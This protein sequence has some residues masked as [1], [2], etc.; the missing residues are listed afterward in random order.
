M[1]RPVSIN[2]VTDSYLAR[3]R[4]LITIETTE[5]LEKGTHGIVSAAF[6]L[7]EAAEN[8]GY[9]TNRKAGEWAIGRKATP[10]EMEE[11][12]KYEQQSWDNRQSYYEDALIDPAKTIK[13]YSYMKYTIDKHAKDEGL[14]PVEWPEGENA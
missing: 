13:N 2:D 4:N 14:T 11:A 3:D 5:L 10:E 9:E 6:A 7:M 8:A 1:A 12:L